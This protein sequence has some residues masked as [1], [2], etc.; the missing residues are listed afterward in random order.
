M[1]KDTPKVFVVLLDAVVQFADMRLIQKTQNFFLEL[2]T[3][4]T[5]NNLDESD[6]LVNGFLHNAIQFSINLAAAIVNAM[7]IEFEFCH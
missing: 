5:G 7:Q 4:F 2:T 1:N 3:P 6:F